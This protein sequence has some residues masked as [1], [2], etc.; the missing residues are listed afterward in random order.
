MAFAAEGRSTHCW[1]G[2]DHPRSSLSHRARA[3]NAVSDVCGGVI[4]TYLETLHA[5]HKA[6][7]LRLDPP[8]PNDRAVVMSS[9]APPPEP[10]SESRQE[11]IFHVV[12][13]A[14]W[15]DVELRPHEQWIMWLWGR[16]PAWKLT[17]I[18]AA[19]AKS[20]DVSIPEIESVRRHENITRA[21]QVGYM[22]SRVLTERGTTE[23]GKIFGGR[24]HSTVLHGMR[25]ME[26][27]ENE[28]KAIGLTVADGPVTWAKQAMRLYAE[29]YRRPKQSFK[30]G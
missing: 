7:R 30:A 23:I 10:K 5:E 1:G 13:F 20:F 8:R 16:R 26:R 17:E 12:K 25:K 11:H 21:R 27:L 3:R 14:Q 19:V 15:I 9:S 18:R 24:D 6:R 22:I 4:V 28:L 2:C 29:L